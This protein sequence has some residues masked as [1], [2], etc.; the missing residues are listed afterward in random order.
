M[1]K[2]RSEFSKIFGESE[3]LSSCIA[4]I[5][6]AFPEQVNHYIPMSSMASSPSCVLFAIYKLLQND[7]VDKEYTSWEDNFDKEYR[8]NN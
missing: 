3:D 7:L 6:D 5:R 1:E 2:E 4:T 8:E